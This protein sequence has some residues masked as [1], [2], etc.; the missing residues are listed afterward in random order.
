MCVSAT[1][2]LDDP[3]DEPISRFQLSGARGCDNA[4]LLTPT[5][6]SATALSNTRMTSARLAHEAATATQLLATFCACKAMFRPRRRANE[7]CEGRDS[8]RAK[9]SVCVKAYAAQKSSEDFRKACTVTPASSTP[10]AYVSLSQASRTSRLPPASQSS[11]TLITGPSAAHLCFGVAF[12]Q[13]MICPM[14]RPHQSRAAIR[15]L[16]TC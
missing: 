5:K 9:L 3:R 8:A 1:R 16:A 7:L 12:C 13:A 4:I 15:P 10:T 14:C 6:R 2:H 11:A